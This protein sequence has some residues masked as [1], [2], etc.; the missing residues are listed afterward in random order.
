[1]RTNTPS[2][3]ESAR[4]PTADAS[5]SPRAIALHLDCERPHPRGQRNARRDG[6]C[7][8][9]VRRF[10]T[11]AVAPD[12]SV[13]RVIQL[14]SLHRYNSTHISDAPVRSYGGG[15]ETTN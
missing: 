4:R 6:R 13:R 2:R 14:Y 7:G 10:R 9:R 1:N 12:R 8:E 11:A 5:T 3:T 15:S